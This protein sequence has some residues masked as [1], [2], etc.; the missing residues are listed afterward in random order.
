MARFVFR[1]APVLRQRERIEEQK[2]QLL[3][4]EQR[5]L[6]DAEA[7]REMLRTRRENLARELIAEHRKLDAEGLRLAYGHLDFLAREI[8]GA[9]YHVA[10]CQQ[11][12]ERARAVLVRATKDRKILDRLQER[13]RE[14]FKVEQ[15]RLE[16]RE[17]D[18]DNARRYH[19]ASQSAHH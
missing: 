16:Q 4:R 14:A 1:L 7:R 10:A 8:T 17:L 19:R 6:A 2:K 5:V 18:D 12:V 3:A 13:Q 11:A 15:L 9:D